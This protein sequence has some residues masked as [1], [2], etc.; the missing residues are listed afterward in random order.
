MK[1]PLLKKQR[2]FSFENIATWQQYVYLLLIGF[3]ITAAF[4]VPSMIYD[5]G[6]FTF[7]GDYNVQ[8]IP[9]WY[10]A[11][12]AVKSGE[13]FWNWESDLGV[14]FIG[15]YAYYMLGSPFFWLS[16]PFP[17]D[18]VPYIM[19]FMLCLKFAISAMTSFAYLKLFVKKV[20]NAVLGALMYAFCSNMVYSIFFFQFNEVFAF[21]PLMLYGLEVLIQKKKRGFFALGIA[22]CLLCNYYLFVAE[23]VFIVLYFLIR[24]T[25]GCWK[26]HFNLKTL[27]SLAF[28]VIVGCGMALFIALPAIY[29]TAQV[30]RASWKIGGWGMLI[31]N[32]T[33]IYPNIFTAFFTPPDLPARPLF[34]PEIDT[35]WSSVACWLPLFS[36][37]GV[38]AYMRR[39]RKKDWL[40]KLL[41]A[42]LVACV[43]PLFN[44]VFQLFSS[45]YYTRWYFML[46]LMFALATALAIERCS[47]GEWSGAFKINAAATALL[48]LPVGILFKNISDKGLIEMI[49]E[50]SGNF[51][52]KIAT[53]ISKFYEKYGLIKYPSKYWAYIA[54]IGI[55]IALVYI[56]FFVIGRKNKNFFKSAFIFLCCVCV[57]YGNVFIFFGKSYDN[58]KK[59]YNGNPSFIEQNIYNR[60]KFEL[61]AH[62]D[63]FVR[64]D[65]PKD[66]REN[67]GLML[68]VPSIRFFH[69]VVPE[70][71]TRFY[72]SIGSTRTVRSE[73]D[74]ELIW[75]R[76]LL[77]VK[78]MIDTKNTEN[79]DWYGF[80]YVATS[81]NISIWE[82]KN[83]IP[84]GFT[85]DKYITYEQYNKVSEDYRDRLLLHGI[86]LSD[87]QIEKYS[88]IYTNYTENNIYVN[89]SM[90]EAC[91]ARRENTVKNFEYGSK[92]FSGS[93]TLEKE[94]L[95][96]F[97]VPYEDGWTAYVNGKEVDIERV[98]VGF[99]AVLCGEGE[100]RIEFKFMPVGLRLG[101]AVTAVSILLFVV[102]LTVFAL[103]EHK[104]K[105]REG[106]VKTVPAVIN[107][108]DEYSKLRDKVDAIIG[109]IESEES[110]E[111]HD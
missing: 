12:A 105:K 10:E 95:V 54:I 36:A 24:L 67:Q 83:Y 41:I 80:E 43:V 103:V 74:P 77:S 90:E 75:L 4:I 5:G 73:P 17:T 50:A 79:P 26:E 82:N 45:S 72:E 2:I 60:D 99:M 110:E 92:G 35:K 59:S 96:F 109:E 61:P 27:L 93:I 89:S 69:T 25:S 66:N 76:S 53:G 1:N 106:F 52:Q 111:D 87:S 51:L 38:I 21:F 8:Q 98:N 88:N 33:Q 85:Y 44:S 58:T 30:P 19:P 108:N 31:F 20:D 39:S 18:W 14:N 37:T 64:V 55:C 100:N 101:S 91:D 6:P 97:S 68:G 15:S 29:A 56:L 57:L 9:F 11:H 42:L 40:Q 70:S 46:G 34:Y 62:S 47:D 28:E 22:L 3:V 81:A 86:L 84:I 65:T 78:Y 49:N 71:I 7:Y 23:V 48:T 102:Y 107:E 63:A 94:T 104:R 16:L 13:I 32:K